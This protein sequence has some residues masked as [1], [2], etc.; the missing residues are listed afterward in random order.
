MGT[1][2]V[3]KDGDHVR[4]GMV[5]I[6]NMSPDAP[7]SWLVYFTVP[8]ADAAVETAKGGGAQV[9]NGPFDIPVGRLAVMA[10]PAGAMFAVMAPTDE[11][12]EN[13]P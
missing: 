9:F 7:S 6:T 1:Y 3:W 8:D 2:H 5:D 12:R 13:A 11:T 10:D 4:G